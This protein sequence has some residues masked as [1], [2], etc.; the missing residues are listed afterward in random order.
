MSVEEGCSLEY[1]SKFPW[2]LERM[3]HRRL[4][5]MTKRTEELWIKHDVVEAVAQPLQEEK[6]SRGPRIRSKDRVLRCS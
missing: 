4:R 6:R 3:T 1:I 5:E 2:D